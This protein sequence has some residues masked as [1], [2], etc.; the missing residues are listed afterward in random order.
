MEISPAEVGAPSMGDPPASATALGASADLVSTKVVVPV[1]VGRLVARPQ[2]ISWSETE[3]PRLVLVDAPAGY[4]KTTFAVESCDR[5]ARGGLATAW[6]SLGGSENDP[7]LYWRYVIAALRVAG[8]PVGER[9]EQLLAIPGVD[10]R[11]AVVSLVNDLARDGRE[12]LLVLDDYHVIRERLIHELMR[13][14]LEHLPPFIQVMV[15][16]RGEPPLGVGSLRAAGQLREIRLNDLRLTIEEARELIAVHEGLV[17][18]DRDLAILLKRTEGW[19]AALHLA[20]LWLRGQADPS[21]AVR[22]FA[23]DHRHIVDYLADQVLAELDPELEA[24]L[25]QTSILGRMCAP[26]CEAVTGQR[27]SADLLAAAERSSL[28]LVAL[29]SGQVWFRY[30]QL[31]A[32]LL[33]RELQRRDPKLFTELHARA[34]GWHREHGT[35][36]EA[37]HHAMLAGDFAEA[38]ASITQVWIPL[39]RTGRSATVLRWLER[40]PADV[41]AA[42]PEVGYIGAITT[43]AA[44][45]SEVEVQRWVQIAEATGEDARTGL[46]PDGT[47]SVRANVNYVRATLLYRDVGAAGAIAAG[48]AAEQRV[49]GPGRVIALASLGWLRYLERDAPAAWAAASEAVADPAAA[50]RPHGLILALATQALLAVDEGDLDRGHRAARHALA[51]AE[52]VGLADC[53]AAGLA[54]VA[55]GR[56]RVRSGDAALGVSEIEA[57]L[58][59]L[60]DHAPAARYIYGLLALAEAEQA[61]GDLVAAN[62]AAD[63]AEA[64]LDTFLDAGL[65]ADTLAAIRSRAQLL[66]R[67]RQARPGSDLSESELAVLRVLATS[68]TRAQIASELSLSRN[69]VKTHLRAIYRKL[70]VASGDAAVTRARELDLL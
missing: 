40:L 14:F 31:F 54:R 56:L 27:A 15:V 13:S 53:P 37:I 55:S 16:S 35:L 10:V 8:L 61:Q 52:S 49:G 19:V 4:G 63:N 1:T 65:L 18:D 33:R 46:L 11:E 29:D 48:V 24:F 43:G 28:F 7:V 5:A 64:M 39:V 23:G 62:R 9:G 21:S 6:V 67:R 66:R 32:E 59:C 36:A 51:T 17:L 20:L 57:A 45:G 42:F 22:R 44:G 50:A 34:A 3:G 58:V 47:S 38:V 26:L 41:A 30:H 60:R 68:R 70:D 69:T 2:L 12:A 25:L